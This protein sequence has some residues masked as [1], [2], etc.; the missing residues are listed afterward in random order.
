MKR[1][2][3]IFSDGELVRK[4]NTLYFETEKESKYI[5]IE[6]TAEIYVMGELSI[7][8]KLLELLCEYEILV[9]F[10]NHYGY[11]VG[12]F[13][14]REHY[15]SGH[16][17]LKQ[18]EFYNS[19]DKRVD[20]A[21]RF[22][23]GAVANIKYVLRYYI[24]RGTAIGNILEHIEELEK[25]IVNQTSCEQLMAIEGNVREQYYSA[26]DEIIGNPEFVFEKRTRQPAS[27]RLNCLISFGN[28][29]LYV[30]V[31][32]EIYKTHLDP[33]I[34][35]LHTT[36]FRRFTLNLDVSEIFK[37]IIVDRL[38]F[39]LL[40]KNMIQPED[41]YQ[42]GGGLFLKERGKKVFVEEFDRKLATTIEYRPIKR[43]VSYR[44]LIRMELYK[45]EK[46][47]LGEKSYEPFT[48]RW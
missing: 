9:H 12:T 41:F 26:F 28:S 3:Y 45:I 4:Q 30:A 2:V 24:N 5:P 34:G 14:P 1:T 19:P 8:K 35:F 33:R 32:S 31:L 38:I 15:N 37:P 7:T 10:F 17:I 44:R 21:K 47:L 18:A 16:M 42:E 11:Y 23:E 6:N 43:A 25:L 20:L 22:V 48:T 40:N 39:K 27:N 46:H 13:Y 36:N 29:L